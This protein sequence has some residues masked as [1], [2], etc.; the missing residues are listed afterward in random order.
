MM[1]SVQMADFV[2]GWC[3]SRL[4]GS[5]HQATPSHGGGMRSC[6]KRL[7]SWALTTSQAAGCRGALLVSPVIPS[8]QI[9]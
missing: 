4:W 7:P 3:P 5:C 8:S 1:I 6:T 9:W 2:H